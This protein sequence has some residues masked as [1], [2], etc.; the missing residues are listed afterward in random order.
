MDWFEII[1]QLGKKID[2]KEKEHIQKFIKW[3]G[4]LIQKFMPLSR[5]KC[6]L[7]KKKKKKML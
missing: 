2:F 4:N 5:C 1:E 3:K 6:K 7:W